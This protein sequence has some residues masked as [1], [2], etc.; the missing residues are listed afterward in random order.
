M[1]H[2]FGLPTV[3]FVTLDTLVWSFPR[4]NHPMLEELGLEGK[5]LITL[6]TFV[7]FFTS[8]SVGVSCQFR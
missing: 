8:V 4:V 5:R 6:R 3:R 1:Y 7:K 2:K